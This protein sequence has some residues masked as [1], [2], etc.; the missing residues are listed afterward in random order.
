MTN[1]VGLILI[2]ASVISASLALLGVL[3]LDTSRSAASEW[4]LEAEVDV[5]LGIQTDN[6]GGN[7]DNLGKVND[8]LKYFTHS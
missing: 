5:L 2:A 8:K 7:V 1:A 4:R 6:E 3:P